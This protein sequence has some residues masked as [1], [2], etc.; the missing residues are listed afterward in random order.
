M[1]ALPKASGM[2]EDHPPCRKTLSRGRFLWI[3]AAGKNTQTLLVRLLKEDK[4]KPLKGS[5]CHAKHLVSLHLRYLMFCVS[6][7]SGTGLFLLRDNVRNM[8]L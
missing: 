3:S 8:N 6:F 1:T 7:L 5:R 4:K 2:V